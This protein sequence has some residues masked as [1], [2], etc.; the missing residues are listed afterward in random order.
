MSCLQLWWTDDAQVDAGTLAEA[1]VS[2]YFT[3]AHEIAHNL[4]GPHNAEHE[5]W[6]SSVCERFMP[7]LTRL[8]VVPPGEGV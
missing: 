4:V 3:L 8:L 2:W 6:F 7:V 5:F 1:S